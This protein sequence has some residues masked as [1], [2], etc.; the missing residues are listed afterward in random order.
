MVVTAAGVGWLYLLFQAAV[1]PVGPRL[2]GAL[3]LQQLASSDAQ[4]L[5]RLVAAWLP[6]GVAAGVLVPG[7]GRVGRTILVGVVSAAV[8]IAAGAVSD[9]VAL[10]E[11]VVPHLGPQ[12]GR[13][14]TWVAVG[15]MVIGS[16]PVGRGRV[17]RRRG[18]VASVR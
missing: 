18:R 1:L 11:R 5:L 10:N 14:G 2:A 12:L 16:L 9:A 15:L 3:P 6:A 4:P 8:L 13:A 7:L 17:G